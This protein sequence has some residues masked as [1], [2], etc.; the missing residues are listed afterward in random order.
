MIERQ[1]VLV[2]D[3]D[4]QGNLTAVA[5]AESVEEDQAGLADALSS[6]A[7]ETI[8]DVL[9][10]TGLAPHRLALE[11]TETIFIEDSERTLSTL[12]KLKELG[13]QI[14]LDD[15]GTG[16]SS[17]SYLRSFPFDTVK[18]DRCFVSDLGTSSS[19]NV[20]VQAV[21]LMATGLGVQTV[22]EGIETDQQ[23]HF[24]R[25]LGCKE[26]QGYRL[27][28]AVPAVKALRLIADWSPKAVS[29]A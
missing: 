26:V 19:C 29:A 28:P 21:I 6:R 8:R 5:A 10:A 25:L 9:K 13:V 1:R 20:I 11:F 17:L 3:N 7:P 27:S 4:P 15:F 12:H 14:A 16:Y 18:I 2:V 23:L 22:A 24:L